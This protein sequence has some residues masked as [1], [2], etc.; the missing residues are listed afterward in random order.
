MCA[1]GF[2]R[3]L[4]HRVPGVC[5][6]LAPELFSGLPDSDIECISS[7]IV[8][9]FAG[10]LQSVHIVCILIRLKNGY[11]GVDNAV[12]FPVMHFNIVT[13]GKI[14]KNIP[15]RLICAVNALVAYIGN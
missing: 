11:R 6:S 3:I 7:D 2:C 5:F 1:L 12:L 14:D 13:G 4:A 8:I 15:L 10:F 9:A